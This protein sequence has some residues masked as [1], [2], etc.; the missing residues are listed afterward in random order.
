MRYQTSEEVGKSADWFLPNCSMIL[1]QMTEE[2][3]DMGG[4][5]V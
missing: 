5:A 1:N 4:L 3:K 2:I